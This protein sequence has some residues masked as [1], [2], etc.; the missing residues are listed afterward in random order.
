MKEHH[1]AVVVESNRTILSMKCRNHEQ[2][3]EWR[4]RAIKSKKS[5]TWVVTKW[6][7]NRSC[8][9]QILSQDHRQLDFEIISEAIIGMMH[10]SN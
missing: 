3:C 5:N 6:V 2:G 8:V 9:S 4:V 10:Y 7:G 1:E